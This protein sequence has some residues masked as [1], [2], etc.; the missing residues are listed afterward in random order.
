MI[1][2]LD[3]HALAAGLSKGM[4]LATARALCPALEVAEQDHNADR[5]LIEQ[6]ASWMERYTPCVGLIASET[7]TPEGVALDI[8]GAAHL[9]GG[10]E[11]LL[12]DSLSRLRAQGFDA[13]AAIAGTL[14]CAAAF[15]QIG[16]AHV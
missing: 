1:V 11:S 14:E 8:T 5:R 7:E 3:H 10:E 15:A 6:I 9:L 13:R 12:A 4:T 2:A 16:R